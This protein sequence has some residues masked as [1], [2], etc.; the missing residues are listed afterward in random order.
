LI[1]L[2]HADRDL[3]RERPN[4]RIIIEQLVVAMTA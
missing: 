1:G 3:R 4:D 2:F